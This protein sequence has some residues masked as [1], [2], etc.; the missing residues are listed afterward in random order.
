MYTNDSIAMYSEL[1]ALH[2]E[3]IEDLYVRWSLK[4]TLTCCTEASTAA[5]K[6]FTACECAL[7]NLEVLQKHFEIYGENQ[8]KAVSLSLRCKDLMDQTEYFIRDQT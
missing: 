4:R 8:T 3:N 6:L 7:D 1:L 5:G 2:A